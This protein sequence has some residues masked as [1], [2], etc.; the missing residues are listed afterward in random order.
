MIYHDFLYSIPSDILIPQTDGSLTDRGVS[1]GEII[2]HLG[3]KRSRKNLSPLHTWV[4]IYHLNSG[5]F[6]M[7]TYD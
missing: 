7:A 4:W 5:M 2:K 3:L 6:K 1:I